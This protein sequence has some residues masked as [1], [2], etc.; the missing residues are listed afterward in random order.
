VPEKDMGLFGENWHN[1]MEQIKTNWE[2]VCKPDDVIIIPGDISWAD[3]IFQMKED[4]EFINSLPGTKLLMKGNHDYWWETLA[5]LEKYK[6]EE[7]LDTVFFMHNNSYIIEPLKV[8]ICGTRGWLLPEDRKFTQ[9]DLKIYNRE[10]GRLRLSLDDAVKKGTERII[11]AFHYPPFSTGSGSEMMD[12]LK[13]YSVE[14]CIFGHIHSSNR[15]FEKLKIAAVE[16]SEKLNIEIQIVS[17]DYLGFKPRL[18]L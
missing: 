8:A 15:H 16:I 18:L 2:S 5:K 11:A 13:E 1:Y 4:F 9:D 3:N 12:I 17:A 7:K 6:A 10:L 14:K